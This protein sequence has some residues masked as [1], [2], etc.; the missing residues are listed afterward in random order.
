[1]VKTSQSFNGISKDPNAPVNYDFL[2][3]KKCDRMTTHNGD[4]KCLNCSQ[5]LNNTEDK[6]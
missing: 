2:Y 6:E 1:M 3:C 5:N 4:G